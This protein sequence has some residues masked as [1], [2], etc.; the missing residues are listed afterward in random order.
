[1]KRIL[2][3]I[4]AMATVVVASNILVQTHRSQ[5]VARLSSRV[6]LFIL[7]FYAPL[8]SRVSSAHEASQHCM[9]IILSCQAQ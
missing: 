6:S 7:P 9:R 2:L 1:M 4:I 5:I 8:G 3:G